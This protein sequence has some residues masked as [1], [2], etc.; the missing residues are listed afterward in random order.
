MFEAFYG[1]TAT[2]FTRALP[3]DALYASAALD[4]IL[5]RLEYAAARQR[6]AV[7]TGDG[8]T[9]NSIAIR[10]L[11]APAGPRPVPAVGPSRT[12]T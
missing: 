8:G 2:P 10:R 6:F 5:G 9:G 11:A 7:V 1:M 12:P 3:P 4:E